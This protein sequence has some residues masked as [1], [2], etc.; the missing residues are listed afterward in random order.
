MTL[1]I[2]SPLAQI[3]EVSVVIPCLN[4]AETIAS[5]IRKASESL[6]EAG[7]SG[8]IIV[9]DNG[10][11]DGSDRIAVELGARVVTIAERGYGSAIMG[12]IAA[13]RGRFII[14]ADADDSYDFGAT[15][16]FVEKLR[17]GYDLVQGCRFPS[18]GGT[19]DE[20]AMPVLHRWVGNPLLSFVAR[21]FFGTPVKDIY[22]GFRGFRREWYTQLNQHCRGMEFATEMIV[23]SALMG[24]SISELPIQLRRDGRITRKPHL[25]TFRDGWR[26]L[27]FYLM[28]SP[29]WTFAYPA[30]LL[31]LFG[32]AGYAVAL[33]GLQIGRVQFDVHTLVVASMAFLLSFQ[34]FFLG[35][36]ARIFAIGAGLLPSTPA[37]DRLFRH[38]NLEKGLLA[39]AAA[40]VGGLILIGVAVMI[41]VRADFG[42]LDYSR[43]MRWVVPGATLTS[44][45]FQT[46]LSS[47]LLSILGIL[48]R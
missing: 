37:T 4:E 18:G 35:A 44:L 6:R 48:R 25:R 15:P 42:P 19:I 1:P 45:G 14:M 26:T 43:T 41:W 21:R 13:A 28:Y 17:D 31:A 11:T 38:V 2:D 46:A 23:K 16:K 39:G 8:E 20:G 9:A 7:M 30:I 47:F 36:A 34:A 32:V 40:T 22:C 3:P 10:S 27:R 5:C 24:G 33:P 29:R 12:G